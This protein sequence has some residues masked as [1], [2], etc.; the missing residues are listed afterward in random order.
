MPVKDDILNEEL[1]ALEKRYDQELER[2]K[3]YVRGEIHGNNLGVTRVI[4]KLLTSPF[5]IDAAGGTD[6][7]G[8]VYNRY[9]EN[10]RV[11][12]LEWISWFVEHELLGNGSPKLAWHRFL[13]DGDN[14]YNYE[15]SEPF[16]PKARPYW[17]TQAGECLSLEKVLWTFNWYEEHEIKRKE[18]YQKGTKRYDSPK[19][20][21]LM[22]HF[23][24]EL[25]DMLK[26]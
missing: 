8:Y 2:L 25:R 1:K 19:E 22:I 18:L 13:L 14:S 5:L 26:A 6:K 20:D 11:R 4:C 15:Q 10:S 3:S 16:G 7:N 23:A 9:L 24:N 12:K 17:S 21:E